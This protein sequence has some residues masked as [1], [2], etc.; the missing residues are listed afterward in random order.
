M[1][2]SPA[3]HSVRDIHPALETG[4]ERGG[5]LLEEADLGPAFFDLRTGLAGE[6]FQQLT[7]YGLR[8]ALVVPDPA[9]HGERFA[10]LAWEHR[11]HP[12]VRIFASPAEAAQ[13]I[14]ESATLRGTG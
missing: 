2:A 8:L 1:S 6:L 9:S 7:N 14:E 11:H 3:I 10:E 13:W 12:T 5:L 4:M